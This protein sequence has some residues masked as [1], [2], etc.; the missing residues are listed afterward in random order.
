MILLLAVAIGV[1]ALA[2]KVWL[3]HYTL[4]VPTFKAQWLVP[5]AALLQVPLLLPT[6]VQ[7]DW[8]WVSFITSLL[9]LLIFV[10][11]NHK[12]VGFWVIG[13]G[14]ALNLLV[15]AGNGGLMPISPEMVSNLYPH[16]SL[17]GWVPDQQLVGSKERNNPCCADKIWP[18]S[19][20]GFSYL[21]SR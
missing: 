6:Q 18:G 13:A 9:L 1:I 4:S 11:L 8:S 16:L 17:Q 20:I 21:L 2:V 7:P 19:P 10:G 12:Q 15:I 3:R 14:I 5:V